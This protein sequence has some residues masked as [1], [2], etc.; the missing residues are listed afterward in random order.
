MEKCMD[1]DNFI[2]TIKGKYDVDDIVEQQL[3]EAYRN[4]M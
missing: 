1:E 2:R 4:L 3:R